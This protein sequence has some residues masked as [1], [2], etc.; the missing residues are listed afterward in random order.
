MIKALLVTS[1][2]SLSLFSCSNIPF[3]NA[4][5]IFCKEFWQDD[6]VYRDKKDQFSSNPYEIHG[7]F[8]T[9]EDRK[10]RL[11]KQQDERNKRHNEIKDQI[12]K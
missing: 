5:T 9:K 3:C 1:M 4:G 11:D 6:L 7:R 12:N 8:E 10:I 2:L